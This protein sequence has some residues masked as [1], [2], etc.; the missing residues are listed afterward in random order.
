M[1]VLR[2]RFERDLEIRGYSDQTKEVY[3]S[4]VRRFARFLGRS[5]D[6][7]TIEDVTRFQHH[8]VRERKISWGYFNQVVCAL[9]LFF[10]L[11][12]K[13]NWKVDLIP[14]QRTGRTLPQVV[15]AEEAAALL[16]ALKNLKHRAILTTAYATGLRASEITHLKI[17]DVDS[18]RMVIRVEQGKRRKDRYVMLSPIL[19]ELLREYWRAYRPQSWLFPGQ[20][21]SRP[22]SRRAIHHI[23]RKAVRAAGLH[24]KVNT[25]GLRHA[26]ATHLLEGGTNIRVIQ[27]LLGHR[28]LTS[29]AVYSHVAG[30]Y[31]T[32][33]ASPLDAL[34]GRGP[35]PSGETR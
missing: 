5:P 21:S 31:L 4:I 29:T 9:R 13:K 28:S 34:S 18:S 22:I 27:L 3:V 32:E 26:F 25:R 1:G 6:L 7:A 15:S 2:D 12:L 8:L 19:L 17:T 33:T 20:D 11:T 30:T 23:C 16:D 24:K 14:H 10:N 35:D